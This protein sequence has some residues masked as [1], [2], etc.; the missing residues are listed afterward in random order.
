VV[1]AVS[2]IALGTWEYYVDLKEPLLPMW[3]VDNRGWIFAT[4]MFGMGAS[5][6]YAFSIVWPTMV[7]LLYADPNDPMGTSWLST[8]VGL[9]IV[10][11]EIF[12]G[13][14]A[15]RIEFIKW[16]L[17]AVFAIGGIFFACECLEMYGITTLLMRSRCC[18]LWSR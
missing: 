10:V 12:D 2:L 6:H 8:L 13:F 14:L 17:V 7:N 15:K 3:V 4:L 16:Q 18:D 9:L 11:G 1:G 5:M